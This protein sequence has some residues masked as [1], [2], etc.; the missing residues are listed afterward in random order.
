MQYTVIH[1][2]HD[3]TLSDNASSYA[4]IIN[5]EASAPQTR[6]GLLLSPSRAAG[7]NPLQDAVHR[8][9]WAPVDAPATGY[10]IDTTRGHTIA[11]VRILH[12]F[13]L[14]NAHFG[15]G[16]PHTKVGSPTSGDTMSPPIR[17]VDADTS[18]DILMPGE[19]L[20]VPWMDLYFLPRYSF[21]IICRSSYIC[22][23]PLQQSG[24][25]A[26]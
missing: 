15:H 20:T 2:G 23:G 3:Q 5:P 1:D 4:Y 18:L 16:L 25:S 12:M 11:E 6:H 26:C 14:N 19:I 22:K 10:T 21:G 9:S 24:F 8:K 17:P 13:T 7:G